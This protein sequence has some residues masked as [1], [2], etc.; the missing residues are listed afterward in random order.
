[1][2]KEKK[3]QNKELIKLWDILCSCWRASDIAQLLLAIKDEAFAWARAGAV[4]LHLVILGW[5]AI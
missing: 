3:T 4:G 2:K 5:D 1:M